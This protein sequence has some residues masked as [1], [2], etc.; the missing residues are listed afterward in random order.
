MSLLMPDFLDYDA[1]DEMW[2][3]KRKKCELIV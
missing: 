2:W 3:R 1:A